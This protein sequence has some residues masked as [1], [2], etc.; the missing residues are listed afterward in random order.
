M[1]H[2]LLNALLLFF[3]TSHIISR[4][5]LISRLL[6]PNNQEKMNIL[7]ITQFFKYLKET[8]T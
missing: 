6:N 3:K 4:T 8:L 2:L 7:I 1:Q 5:G